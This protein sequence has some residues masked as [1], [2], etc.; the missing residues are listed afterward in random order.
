MVAITSENK[1]HSPGIVSHFCTPPMEV[2][3]V[4]TNWEL[5]VLSLKQTVSLDSWSIVKV[6]PYVGNMRIQ[7]KESTTG[8]K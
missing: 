4:H 2:M 3:Q 1:G 5:G 8:G 7:E 6:N